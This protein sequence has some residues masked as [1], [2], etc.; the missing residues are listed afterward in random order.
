[1]ASQTIQKKLI[2][3]RD[4]TRKSNSKASPTE[5]IVLHSR[6]KKLRNRMNGDLKKDS[7]R[8]NNERVD[9]AQDENEIWKVVNDLNNPK[10]NSNMRIK[11]YL[12]TYL[13]T[14]LN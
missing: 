13:L 2:K 7:L 9:K 4:S 10:S 6:Y 14:N 11:H 3:D 5:K 8:F 1:M 12:L